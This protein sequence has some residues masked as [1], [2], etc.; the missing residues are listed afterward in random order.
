MLHDTTTPGSLTIEASSSARFS[1][2][3]V[4]LVIPPL[5]E[6]ENLAHLNF[7][8]PCGFTNF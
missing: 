3:K 4:S 2:P 6:T 1:L 5:N 8:S 7:A